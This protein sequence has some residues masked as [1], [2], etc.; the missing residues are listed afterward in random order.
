M[1]GGSFH[2]A[3][4]SLKA[5]ADSIEEAV[6][7]H[8]YIDDGHGNKIDRDLSDEEVKSA[9]LTIYLLRVCYA[10]VHALD[11]RIDNDIGRDTYMERLKDEIQKVKYE[12]SMRM[13]ERAHA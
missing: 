6:N 5:M 2:P 10:R 12:E 9:R 7:D 11:L 4:Y 8:L 13:M 3:P 1:S